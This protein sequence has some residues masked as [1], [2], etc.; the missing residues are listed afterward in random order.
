MAF[1]LDIETRPDESLREVFGEN[2]SAPGNIKDP[3]K[4]AAAIAKKLENSDKAMAVDPDYAR[5]VCI[6]VKEIGLPGKILTLEEFVHWYT[7]ETIDARGERHSKEDQ[8]MITF[9]GKGFDIPLLIK[10]GIKQ[11]L[12][13]PYKK[14]KVMMSKGFVA[15]GHVD[16]MEQIG[17]VW[18]ENKS[19][20]SYLQIYCGTKKDT[21]GNEFF[22][23]ATD[24]E[25]AKHCLEDLDFTEMLYNKFS[26]LLV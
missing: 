21:K 26:P 3:E 23:N 4:I 7:A 18:G 19:L 20:D 13:L 11:G 15:G 14:L 5:I 1:I 22:R 25:L 2:V 6:G 10:A 9:N 16:M 17:M 8:V 12:K 24:E